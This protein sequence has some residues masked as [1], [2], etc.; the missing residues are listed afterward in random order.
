MSDSQLAYYLDNIQQ[1]SEANTIRVWF[2]Q[3]QG[4]PGKWTNFDRV[5]AALKSRGMRAVVTLTNG[6]STCDEPS[7]PTLYKTLTWYQTGYKSPEGGYA[8]S[9]RAYAADVAARYAN[10]PTVAL[11]QLV[12]EASA[13]TLT[14]SGQ[15]TCDEAPAAAALRAFSDDMVADIHGVDTNHLI[16]LGTQN[17]GQCGM[18]AAD[19]TYIHAGSVDLCEYHDYGA[20][21]TAMPTG[22]DSLTQAI[23]DCHSLGKPL[24]IGESGIPANVGPD[25]TPNATCS[26]WPTCSPNAITYATLDQRAQFFQS[27]ISAANQAGVAGYLIWVKS[28][29]Y[30]DATD[31]YAISDGDPTEAQLSTALQGYPPSGALPE[32]PWTAGLLIAAVVAIGGGTALVRRRPHRTRPKSA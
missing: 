19:Y 22:P 4:G 30:T 31:G 11:W 20:P 28:P 21:G 25:G 5:I 29:Y 15:L 13:N 2:F 23:A 26:P 16:N 8:L 9:F 6:T 12:N 17:P 18:Q 7:A 3:S 1:N 24:F 10:Q 27:K 14:S 32:T